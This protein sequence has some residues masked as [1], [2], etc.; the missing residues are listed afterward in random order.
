MKF[1]KILIIAGTVIFFII[2][3]VSAVLYLG[4][5]EYRLAEGVAVKFVKEAAS[6]HKFDQWVSYEEIQKNNFE[7]VDHEWFFLNHRTVWI[8]ISFEYR[9]GVGLLQP[10]GIRLNKRLFLPMFNTEKNVDI[11]SVSLQGP[12]GYV[13]QWNIQ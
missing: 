12:N 6:N 9:V 10:R 1:K 11:Y 7:V 2:G 3:L 5:R 13:G 4:S 8:K